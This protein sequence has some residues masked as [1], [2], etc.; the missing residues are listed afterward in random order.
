MTITWN[1]T[2]TGNCTC[3]LTHHDHHWWQSWGSPVWDSW[4]GSP[5]WDSWRGSPVWDSWW[6]SPVWDSWQD[7]QSCLKHCGTDYLLLSPQAVL[8]VK[9]IYLSEHNTNVQQQ[10]NWAIYLEV[11]SNLSQQHC[12]LLSKHF[13][14][15]PKPPLSF[16]PTKKSEMSYTADQ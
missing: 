3:S 6:G 1:S 4:W 7:V 8:H 11:H 12:V 13:I 2:C 15:R 9:E 14:P 5:V 10:T 16:I